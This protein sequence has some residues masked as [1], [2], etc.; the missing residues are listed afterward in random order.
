MPEHPLTPMRKLD[1]AF[2]EQ[3]SATNTLVFSDGALSRK[4]KLLIALA[5]DAAEGADDGVRSL[6][7][8]VLKEGGTREEI[9]EALRVAFYLTGVG[10]LY[11]ASRGL[12]DI[13]P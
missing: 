10:C 12:R 5:F 4:H 13:L 7:Q 1:P 9:A 2:M 11:S 8:S 3:V 6:A